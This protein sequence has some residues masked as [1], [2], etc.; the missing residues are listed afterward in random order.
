MFL[1]SSLVINE[2]I[3]SFFWD[4]SRDYEGSSNHAQNEYRAEKKYSQII[5]ITTNAQYK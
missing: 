4:R 3:L 2:S 1:P 5:I